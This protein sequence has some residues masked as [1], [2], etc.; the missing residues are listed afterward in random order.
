M[1]SNAK[2]EIE[3]YGDTAQFENSLKGV[4]TAMKGLKGEASQLKRELRLDPTNTD[5]MAQLQKNLQQ[6]LSVTK[7]KSAELRKELSQI[8]RSTPKGNEEFVKLSKQLKDSEI[9]AGYL[10]KEIGQVDDAL[11]R[12]NWKLDVDTAPAEKKVGLL[13][14]TFAG[15]KQVGIGALRSIGERAVGAVTGSIGGWI[16]GAKATQKAMNALKNTMNFSGQ[17]KEFS[18]LSER[19]QKLATDTNANAEDTL[20]L[21]TTFVGLGDNSKVAGNKVDSLVRANQAFGGTSESLKGVA[22]AYGQM[23]AAGKVSAENIGQ[24]TD[25]NTA[26]GSSLKN[27][28]MQMNPTLKKYGSFNAASEKGA[29]SVDMLDAAMAKL[30]KAGGGSVQTIDDAMDS[31]NETISKAMVPA[32]VAVTPIITS[33]INAIGDGI[34]KAIKW[35]GLL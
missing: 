5:K 23:S 34:P 7:Q 29:I 15:L 26:L 35:F 33:I 22:Q 21:A 18:G 13:K 1:A 32:L 28:V 10:E 2:F 8:D 14:T 25:N 31:L 19:M 3:I 6:Q 9:Q 20:K 30:G 16:D 24:L 17:G 27:T 12:G 4:N 11:K